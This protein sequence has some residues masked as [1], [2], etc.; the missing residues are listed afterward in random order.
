MRVH[1]RWVG[2]IGDA[3]EGREWSVGGWGARPV[4]DQEEERARPPETFLRSEAVVDEV[5][6]DAQGAIEFANRRAVVALVREGE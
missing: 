5:V 3:D 2:G 1:G 6:T 4:R